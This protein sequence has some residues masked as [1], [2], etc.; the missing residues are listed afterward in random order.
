MPTL[1][2][3]SDEFG[4]DLPSLRCALGSPAGVHPRPGPLIQGGAHSPV[5]QPVR[6]FLTCR[7][8]TLKP[9]TPRGEHNAQAVRTLR[10]PPLSVRARLGASVEVGMESRSLYVDR[11]AICA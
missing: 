9:P 8:V 1:G 10:S 5:T 6:T 2:D 11:A 3:V 4:I 7:S